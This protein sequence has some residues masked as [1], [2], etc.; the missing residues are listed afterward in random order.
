MFILFIVFQVPFADARDFVSIPVY[1]LKKPNWMSINP[2]GDFIHRFGDIEKRSLHKKKDYTNEKVFCSA[3]RAFRFN[4]NDVI[5]LAQD[6]HGMVIHSR[7]LF[8]SEVREI[9]KDSKGDGIYFENKVICKIEMG[10]LPS[11]KKK[12]IN[13]PLSQKDLKDLITRCLNLKVNIELPPDRTKTNTLINIGKYLPITY[14]HATTEKKAQ[15]NLPNWLIKSGSPLLIVE[16][17]AAELKQPLSHD[18]LVSDLKEHNIRIFFMDLQIGNTKLKTWFVETTNKTN[19]NNVQLLLEGLLHINASQQCLNKILDNYDKYMLKNGTESY[20]NFQRYLEFTFHS[21]FK[22]ERFGFPCKEFSDILQRCEDT[23]SV[24]ETIKTELKKLGLKG[25]CLSN[26]NRYILA[27]TSENVNISCCDLG[28][29][30][31]LNNTKNK[32]DILILTAVPDEFNGV[33]AAE[34]DWSLHNDS[35]G[36]PYYIRKDINKNGIE[37]SFALACAYDMGAVNAANLATRLNIELEPS[38]LAMVGIC[39]G[40]RTKVNLGDVIVADRVFNYDSGKLISHTKGK[41]D[42]SQIFHDIRTYNLKPLWKR[43]A[44]HMSDDWKKTIINKRPLE[45]NLQEIWLLKEVYKSLCGDSTSPIS[46]EEKRLYCPDWETVVQRLERKKLIKIT[47]KMELTEKGR[48]LVQREL[49]IHPEG[50]LVPKEANVFVNAI[51]TGNK[52]IEDRTIFST[53]SKNVRSVLGL[54]MEAFA[55]GEIA[56]IEQI[57]NFII[58]KAV[59]DYAD[60]DKDD[61]FRTYAIEAS[62]RF[63]KCFLKENY[64]Q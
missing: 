41:F 42:E 45:Y 48:K 26:L 3:K 17:R 44:L 47:T 23:V 9:G 57:N 5:S 29:E 35:R 63:M 12:F 4:Q 54:E 15:M 10:F 19:P 25:N 37:I 43:K 16:F 14:L 61:H 24:R 55:I 20:Y 59:S 32:V 38:C 58:A 62:Y 2:Y 51:A 18:C 11:N 13:S 7:R 56:A 8:P 64:E 34:S 50:H 22:R 36:Y 21:L 30:P 60:E 40:W 39:A 33:L 49:I 53:I 52:V 6:T 28:G 27:T 1:R 46:N 31:N